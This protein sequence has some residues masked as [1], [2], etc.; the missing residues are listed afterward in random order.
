MYVGMF[1][2]PYT[3]RCEGQ[4][5]CAGGQDRCCLALPGTSVFVCLCVFVY[6]CVYVFV[7]VCVCVCVC[8]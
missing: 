8:L 5:Q 1:I 3:R 7:C 6:V 2:Y 4:D